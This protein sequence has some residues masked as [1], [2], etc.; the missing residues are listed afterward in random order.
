MKLPP[1]DAKPE[2]DGLWKGFLLHLSLVLLIF[3]MGI[4]LGIFF[5][6]EDLFAQQ[7]LTKAQA[8]FE[9]ILMARRWNADFHGV[10]VEKTPGVESNSYLPDPDR[11]ARMAGCTP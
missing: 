7:N 2:P 9:S 4:F 11:A 10:F 3:I 6:N 1:P 8:C 5:R